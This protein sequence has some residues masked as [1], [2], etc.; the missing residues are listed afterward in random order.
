M[1]PDL[2]PVFHALLQQQPVSLL[3][4]L[5]RRPGRATVL[6]ALAA[7]HGPV[8]H[9][10]L[11]QLRP[12][13]VVENLRMHLVVGGALPPRDERLSTFERWV[14]DDTRGVLEL[15]QEIGRSRALA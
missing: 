3:A 13:K 4:W 14:D 1:S 11:D 5:T 7:G 6:H 10:T 2:D 15:C 12:T 8:T 9:N